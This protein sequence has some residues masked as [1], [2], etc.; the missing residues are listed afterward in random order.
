MAS[1]L[2]WGEFADVD[3]ALA[4]AGAELLYHFGVGLGFL[5]TVGASGAPRVHPMCP[6][7]A[8]GELYCFIV[9]SPKQADLHRDGRFAL[10]SFPMEDNE[11]AFYLSGRAVEVTE[12]ATRERVSRQF[13][14]ERHELAVPPPGEQDVLF[15]LLIERAMLTRTTG[16]GDPSPRHTV[17]RANG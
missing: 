15:R 3:A 16:H 14:D 17:W 10:H 13:T 11:D 6:V 5:A 9:P 7:L 2:T 1:V 12:A 8:H 4:T